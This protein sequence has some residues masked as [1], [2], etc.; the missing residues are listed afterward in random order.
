MTNMQTTWPPGWYPDPWRHAESRWWDGAG[1]TG[2]LWPPTGQSDPPSAARSGVS[3]KAFWPSIGWLMLALVVANLAGA[4]IAIPL[5]LADVSEANVIAAALFVVYPVFFG[6]MYLAARRISRRHGSGHMGADYG[7]RRPRA[8]DLGWGA[9][10]WFTGLI[11][12][13][14]IGALLR[15]DDNRTGEALLGDDPNTLVYVAA[16]IA[17]IVGAPLFEELYFRG[18]I[19]HSL[20]AR[21]RAPIAIT[22]QAFIF[23]AYHVIPAPQLARLYYVLPI[24]ALGLVF[25]TVAYRTKSLAA[26]QIAHFVNNA[27][28]FAV[29]A[30]TS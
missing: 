28:A 25:G 21:Y 17:A 2:Y 4:A 30:A 1:W 7:W 20:L 10:A 16:G 18:P 29:L 13:A 24:F 11:L 14:V 23:M 3:A 19:M 15:V 9:L 12:S 27:L 5:S 26:A 6:G 8:S 22:L